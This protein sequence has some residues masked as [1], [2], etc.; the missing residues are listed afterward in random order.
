MTARGFAVAGDLSAPT[1]FAFV[2]NPAGDHVA[3]G[4]D[5]IKAIDAVL[6]EAVIESRGLAAPDGPHGIDLGQAGN[7]PNT[8][9]IIEDIPGFSVSIWENP[10]LEDALAEFIEDQDEFAL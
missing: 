6:R 9:D 10:R 5:S 1:H 8:F 3:V 4:A 2:T 7:V